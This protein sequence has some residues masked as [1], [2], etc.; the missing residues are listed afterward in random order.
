MGALNKA[1]YMWSI[2]GWAGDLKADC[3]ILD[4]NWFIRDIKHFSTTIEEY[5]V[6]Y[7]NG[8]PDCIILLK[9]NF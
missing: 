8:T 9:E 6:K 7:L 3:L 5:K 4:E 2:R 1:K